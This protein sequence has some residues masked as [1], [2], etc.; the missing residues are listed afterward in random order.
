M[1]G[2]AE[3]PPP[4]NAKNG[5]QV[6]HDVLRIEEIDIVYAGTYW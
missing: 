5:V 4:Q 1:A 6:E 3:R 2:T